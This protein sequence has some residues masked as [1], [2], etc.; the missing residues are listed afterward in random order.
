MLSGVFMAC[1]RKCLSTL[2]LRA[3][4]LF[5]SG[6]DLACHPISARRTHSSQKLSA[7]NHI[8]DTATTRTP[9]KKQEVHRSCHV[10]C[11]GC[12]AAFWS[13]CVTQSPGLASHSA[14]AR[15]CFR[16]RPLP[17]VRNGARHDIHAGRLKT[18]LASADI[19]RTS[20]MQVR[21]TESYLR[22]MRINPH[23]SYSFSPPR[24]R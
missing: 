16:G 3:P 2:S 20:V 4:I 22:Q 8:P 5:S 15:P 6:Y 12:S 19:L 23:G 13:V 9:P 21:L 18:N 17:C 14:H 1:I 7:W 11:P 10:L 24:H